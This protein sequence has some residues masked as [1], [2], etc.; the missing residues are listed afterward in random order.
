MTYVLV[1]F[2]VVAVV[3][4]VRLCCAAMEKNPFKMTRVS[5]R[6]QSSDVTI[7]E[8]IGW[9]FILGFHFIFSIRGILVTAAL[10]C[11][12]YVLAG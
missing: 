3:G 8:W 6:F 2:V 4:L 9:T 1:I 11:L 5:L 12:T 7:F 10:C